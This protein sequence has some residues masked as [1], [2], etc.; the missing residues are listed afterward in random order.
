[1]EETSNQDKESDLLRK[2]GNYINIHNLNTKRGAALGLVIGTVASTLT[3]IDLN[4]KGEKLSLDSM[5]ALCA[6]GALESVAILAGVGYF[7]QK[8][9]TTPRP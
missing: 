7:N 3:V 9:I 4:N 5:I 8:I 2:I 1:M 6:F